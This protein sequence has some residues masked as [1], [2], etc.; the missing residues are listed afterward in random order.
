MYRPTPTLQLCAH[1]SHRRQLA[2]SV[3]KKS[4]KSDHQV[5]TIQEKRN[6]LVRR[7]RKWQQVQAAYMPG[8]AATSVQISEDNGPGNDNEPAETIPLLLP[9]S[10]DA[11]RRSKICLHGVAEHEQLL[12]TAQLQDSL[13]ELR[14]T[15]KI[16]HKLLLNHHVQIAGQGQRASTRSRSV[17]QSVED[18]IAKFVERYRLAYNALL[19]LDPSGVW[20]ERFLELKNC[21]NRG[22]GKEEYELRLGDGSYFR[23]WIWL[24]NPQVAT[25]SRGAKGGLVDSNA[26]G[27]PVC[28]NAEG[29]LVNAGNAEGGPVDADNAEGGPANASDAEGGQPNGVAV[30]AADGGGEEDTATQEEVNDLVR[31]EWTTA[32]ARLERWTEE[33]E[34]LEEE[35]RRVVAFL[36]WKSV[37]WLKKV[38]IRG[39]GLAFDIRSGLNAYARKQAA[40]YHNLAISFAALWYPTLKSYELQH[41][42]ITEYMKEHGMSPPDA[43]NPALRGRGIFKFRLSGNSKGT[44]G[45]VPPAVLTPSKPPPPSGMTVPPAVVAPSKPPPLGKTVGCNLILEEAS[46]SDDSGLESDRDSEVDLD[47]DWDD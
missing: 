35:M 14:H 30:D 46:Y 5:A 27:R 10:L 45:T 17:L 33:V 21:D 22:P 40:I 24:V 8:V 12:R 9:S 26:E 42:W 2:L 3:K 7:I 13:V 11:E 20:R 25:S 41:S 29:G 39:E 34:L 28:G 43:D 16:R 36:E 37:D 6:G 38:D 23:S 32:F 4:A 31:V 44:K 1:R 15:R 47:S 18:R 19:Q